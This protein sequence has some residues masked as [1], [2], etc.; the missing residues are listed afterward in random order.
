MK[1][2]TFAV[3]L[4]SFLMPAVQGTNW[5]ADLKA[6]LEAVYT[7]TV[8]ARRLIA[9][10]G[11]VERPGVVLVIQQPGIRGGHPDLSLVRTSTVR[12]GALTRVFQEA[13]AGEYLYKVGDRVYVQRVDVDDTVVALRLFTVDPITWS[14]KGTTQVDRFE[15]HFRFEFEKGFLPSGSVPAIKESIGQFLLT[16]AAA[17]SANTKTISLG[18]T[19]AEVE[20]ILGKPETIINLGAKVTYVYKNMKVIFTDGKVTDVQ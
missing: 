16:E 11:P 17:A 18:Q 1:A 19:T 10:T 3:A 14:Y 4:V 2:I 5:K 12:N 9:R 13:D 8:L 15:V 6:K 7:P 20:K